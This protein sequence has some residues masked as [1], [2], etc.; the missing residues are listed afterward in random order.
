MMGNY[1]SNRPEQ[2]LTL[3]VYACQSEFVCILPQR[4]AS[5]KGYMADGPEKRQL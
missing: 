3:F 5:S 2:P 4:G 1:L